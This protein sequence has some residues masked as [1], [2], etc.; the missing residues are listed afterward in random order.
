MSTW[1]SDGTVP[2]LKK[3]LFDD[4]SNRIDI[5]LAQHNVCIRDLLD[6]DPFRPVSWSV[7]L[8]FIHALYCDGRVRMGLGKKGLQEMALAVVELSVRW[9]QYRKGIEAFLYAVPAQ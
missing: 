3:I 6:I 2:Q 7:D 8:S 9:P 5:F 4:M 1:D